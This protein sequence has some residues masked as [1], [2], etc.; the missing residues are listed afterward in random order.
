MEKRKRINSREAEQVQTLG[1][2]CDILVDRFVRWNLFAESFPLVCCLTAS[3]SSLHQKAWTWVQ[4]CFKDWVRQTHRHEHTWTPRYAFVHQQAYMCMQT[5]GIGVCICM[6]VCRQIGRH[7][8]CYCLSWSE[9]ESSE[10]HSC[11]SCL[12]PFNSSDHFLRQSRF[13]ILLLLSFL[14]VSFPW[15]SRS[16]E[17]VFLLLILVFVLALTTSSWGK[18]STSDSPLLSQSLSVPTL[19]QT[20]CISPVGHSSFFICRAGEAQSSSL[21]I[22]VFCLWVEYFRESFNASFCSLGESLSQRD[23]PYSKT[24]P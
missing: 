2:Y 23:F 1:I 12:K 22:L 7:T 17:S 15:Y 11:H 19:C 6:C 20:P 24:Y 13:M 3:F 10:L 8:L 14:L 5:H 16:P 9:L 4:G 18:L 21:L